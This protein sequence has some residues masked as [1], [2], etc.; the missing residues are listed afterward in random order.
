MDTV[1]LLPMFPATSGVEEQF[2]VYHNTPWVGFIAWESLRIA[3]RGAT[4]AIANGY[5]DRRFVWWDY[6]DPYVLMASDVF[7]ERLTD[8]DVL[9]FLNKN[10]TAATIPKSTIVDGDLIV[11]GSILTDHLSANAVTAEKILAGNISTQ[12]LAVGAVGAEAIAAG[13]VLADKIFAGAVSADKIAANAVGAVAIAAGA[14]LADK[15]DAGAVTAVKIAAGAII[16]EKIGAGAVTADKIAANA[17]TAVKI[18]AGAVTADKINV[19]T[20]S[21]ISANMGSV[22]AGSIATDIVISGM[23]LSTSSE[24]ALYVGMQRDALTGAGTSEYSLADFNYA[25]RF[26][27]SGTT[28]IA[29]VELDLDRDGLGADLVLEIRSGLLADGSNDGTLLATISVPKEHLPD[30]K[31]YWSIPVNVRNLTAGALYWLVVRRAGDATNKVD[32]VGEASANANYPVYRRAGTSGAWTTGQNAIHFCT[33]SG[34]TGNLRHVLYTD[35][36]GHETY[37]W[38]ILGVFLRT[39]YWLPS[40]AGGIRRIEDVFFAD[41]QYDRMVRY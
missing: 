31:A 15:I 10:G 20:L 36:G 17:V 7:P 40:V 11:P 24:A 41:N 33:Y 25:I 21:A 13:A 34:R 29:R 2:R 19:A 28:E 14:V 16:A 26:T 8:D 37:V 3:Y 30:P 22:I 9:V 35:S 38:D 18:E 5:T 1:F 27:A 39:Y 6:D 4:Y 23:W 32:L 12:H